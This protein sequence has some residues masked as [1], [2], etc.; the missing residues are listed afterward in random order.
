MKEPFSLR[1]ADRKD[2]E[3]GNK[4]KQVLDKRAANPSDVLRRLIDAYISRD[5]DVSF[6]VELVEATIRQ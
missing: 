6:P 3:R 1:I 5:G 4:F 2:P